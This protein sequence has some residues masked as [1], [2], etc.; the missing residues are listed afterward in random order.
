MDTEGGTCV[1][2]SQ[3]FA[4]GTRFGPLL[5][6][7]SYIPV[8]GV[9]FPLTIFPTPLVEVAELEPLYSGR[10]IYLDTTDENKCNWMIHV[11]TANFSN[12]QNLNAYQHND[13]IY[14][15][16]IQDIELGD[17]LKVWYSPIYAAR[18]GVELLKPS[19]YD[20]C[21]NLLRQVSLFFYTFFSIFTEKLG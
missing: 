19:T 11:N 21:N 10:N 4:K 5:A 1:I 12:E 2:T 9:T 17:I 7:K 8:K 13:S 6:E 20:I 3:K 18:M 16:A 14:Y 15:V